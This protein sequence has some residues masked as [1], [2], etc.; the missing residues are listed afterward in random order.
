MG[1]PSCLGL[2]PASAQLL[3]QYSTAKAPSKPSHVGLDAAYREQDLVPADLLP[4]WRDRLMS[5]EHLLM[6]MD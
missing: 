6:H 1:T 4:S 3:G 5:G 2:L